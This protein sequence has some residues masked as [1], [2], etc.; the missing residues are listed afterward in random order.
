MT[1]WL[2]YNYRCAGPQTGISIKTEFGNSCEADEHDSL[3]ATRRHLTMARK[4]NKNTK[5]NAAEPAAKGKTQQK[6]SDSR[7]NFRAFAAAFGKSALKV[8]RYA[9]VLFWERSWALSV[10]VAFVLVL[11]LGTY[12]KT[13]PAWTISSDE[14][15][16]NYCGLWGAWLADLML[17]SF[18][19]SAWWFVLGF[20]MIAIFAVRSSYRRSRG[21]TQPDRVN[22]PKATA[23]IGFISVLVGSVGLEALRLGGISSR[24]VDLSGGI[25]GQSLAFAVQHYIGIGLATVVFFT[26][27]VIGLSLF[28]DFSWMIVCEKVGRAV[29]VAFVQRFRKSRAEDDA[30]SPSSSNERNAVVGKG[31][32]ASS[33]LVEA[34]E[35][36]ASLQPLQTE[37]EPA[38]SARSDAKESL[39]IIK[40]KREELERDNTLFAAELLSSGS[41]ASAPHPSLGLLKDP[42]PDGRG[43]SQENIEMTSRLI[44]S[45]LKSYGIECKV[46]SAQPGPVITQYWIEPGEGVKGSQIENTRDDLRRA[47]GVQSVR[48]VQNIPGTS[49][50]GIEV[51]NP[52]RETVR[53]KEIL[54]SEVYETSKS[55]LSLA[56]GKDIGGKPFVMDLAKTPHLLVAGTTGSGKSVGVNSMILSMLYRTDPSQLRLVLIDPKML[57]FSP[58][59]GIPHLLCPVV[60][61]M[62]KAATALKWLAREMDR[63]YA[64]MSKVMVRSFSL[65][66]EKVKKAAAEGAPIRDPMAADDDPN[67][68]FLEPWPYIVCIIDELADLM[69]TNRKEVEGEITR[70]TQKA[71][72]AGIHLIIATQRP[73]VDVVTSLI[74]ANVPT[75]ISFQ[76]ASAIDSRVILGETGAEQLLGYGD[77][78]L[79]RPGD[80]ACTRIQGCFVDD[81]EVNA[82]VE[83]L[84]KFG[85]P[86]YINEVV[87]S[88]EV[89]ESSAGAGE[90]RAG[91]ND[92]L[93]DKAVSVVLDSKRP[94]ISFV[95]RQL[96]IGYNRA[97]NLIEAM[98]AAGIVSKASATGKREILVENY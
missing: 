60:T 16:S 72:A 1:I 33:P 62:N 92:P 94:S 31:E 3:A 91:E 8:L 98:E 23:F 44:V 53:L 84:K 42:D 61:D 24:F 4:A 56:I 28:L 2:V 34:V 93:Y 78:L 30:P 86:A 7:Q 12:S 58:Y 52:T 43:V 19:V 65:F 95:Q 87:E 25:L 40:P 74:K 83:E 59:D 48:I 68:P 38:V 80:A 89:D 75:R 6:G 90:R 39:K 77:M 17:K 67:P 51:P 13:D 27:I 54:K 97:A 49:Y 10:P 45:K 35:P 50:L 71:R 41:D 20:L 96:G 21:E 79:H 11:A 55:L 18:G 5:T 64:V 63:R 14:L 47:L 26:L 46:M 32:P 73:S 88:V 29:D 57:E 81:D 70:L 15:V 82:V 69:L 9:G 66:N 22:P 37:L 85:S 76:V 36:G